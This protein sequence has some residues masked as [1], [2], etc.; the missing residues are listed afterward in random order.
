MSVFD[1]A[2]YQIISD[3]SSKILNSELFQQK[4][5]SWT[6]WTIERPRPMEK[7]EKNLDETRSVFKLSQCHHTWDPTVKWKVHPLGRLRIHKKKGWYGLMVLIAKQSS[8]RRKKMDGGRLRENEG[9][10]PFTSV[11]MVFS[12]EAIERWRTSIKMEV[13]LS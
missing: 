2:M 6:I 1:H 8:K 4:A 5:K 13:R 10:F 12:L 9:V 3:P 7:K 11:Y